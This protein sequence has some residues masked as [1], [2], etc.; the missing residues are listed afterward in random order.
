MSIVLL[1]TA[2]TLGVAALLT[3]IRLTIGPTILDRSVALDVLMAVTIC[4]I[5]VYSIHRHT[6]YALPVLLVLSMVGFVG[7]VSIARYASGTDDIEAEDD[8][9]D[10]RGHP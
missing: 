6:T 3:V 10:H 2:S 5:A 7:S 9:D 1:L 8:S 4:G